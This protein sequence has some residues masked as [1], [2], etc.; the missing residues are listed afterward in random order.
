MSE[1]KI[2]G[3]GNIMALRSEN[4]SLKEENAALRAKCDAVV[5]IAVRAN[6]DLRLQGEP[7]YIHQDLSNQLIKMMEGHN[8]ELAL[9]KERVVEA[10]TAYRR[11]CQQG[12][13][14]CLDALL[15]EV[16]KAG[17]DLLE[18]QHVE[19]SE[20]ISEDKTSDKSAD[21][22]RV[23]NRLGYFLH[24]PCPDCCQPDQKES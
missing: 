22:P 2:A 8:A 5:A 16:Q 19:N 21:S 7:E 4:V 17:D 3:I 13:H 1:D 9:A 14:E 18:K 11:A 24:P 12:P 6:R 20:T 23:C 15:Q 10:V